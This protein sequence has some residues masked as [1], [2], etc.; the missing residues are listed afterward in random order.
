MVPWNFRHQMHSTFTNIVHCDLVHRIMHHIR[1]T[2][3]LESSLSGRCGN[4]NILGLEIKFIEYINITSKL[5]LSFIFDANFT[6][7]VFFTF[8]SRR[9]FALSSALHGPN[10][11]KIIYI[12]L[13]LP[14]TIF[15]AVCQWLEKKSAKMECFSNEI[16]EIKVFAV[17]LGLAFAI[18]WWIW[19]CCRCW[20]PVVV[21]AFFC[22]EMSVSSITSCLRDNCV[23]A[24]D[25]AR[26]LQAIR[27]SKVSST[28]FEEI[29]RGA[30]LSS[31]L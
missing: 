3:P 9:D 11:R 31:L 29:S 12:H 7:I 4:S 1:T 5:L 8:I 15:Q 6:Y 21:V 10:A 2:V 18:H 23:R 14:P 16:V 26:F 19:Y 24:I 13:E 17:A 28:E 27:Y 22:L 25:S 20:I 30:V